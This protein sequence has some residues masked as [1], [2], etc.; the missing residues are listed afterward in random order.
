MIQIF[1]K[2]TFLEKIS[3]TKEQVQYNEIITCNQSN[4]SL[5]FKFRQGRITESIFKEALCEVSDYQ[6]MLNPLKL[7]TITK[8][9]CEPKE[10]DFKS[11]AAEWC[12]STSM[13]YSHVTHTLRF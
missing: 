9:L 8:K 2:S 3:I 13:R 10:S 12:D 4:N 1:E 7:K 6:K 11:K 5:W